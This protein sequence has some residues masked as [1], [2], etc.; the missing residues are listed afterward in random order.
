MTPVIAGFLI[1]ALL[2]L[3]ST[4]WDT[5]HDARVND[6]Y[7]VKDGVR[8]AAGWKDILE[9]VFYFGFLGASGA[10]ATWLCWM[11]FNRTEQADKTKIAP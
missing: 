7:Y 3:L 11:H 9:P 10:I 1:G 2:P 5:T 8:T 6:T 4:N